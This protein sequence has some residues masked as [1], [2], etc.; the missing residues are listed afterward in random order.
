MSG[1]ALDIA[2]DRLDG[3]LVIE[4]SAGTGKTYSVAAIV[5]RE[6]ALSEDLRIGQILIT[7]FTRN[8][9]AELRDRVRRRLASTI[10]MLRGELAAGDDPVVARIVA[11]GETAAA[12]GRLARALVEFDSA[13]I[14][15]IHGVCVRVLRAAG[16]EISLVVDADVTDR[17]VA[18]VVNDA[19]VGLAE[20]GPLWEEARLAVLVRA[21]LADP[22]LELWYDPADF[23][24]A[25][26]AR[27]ESLRELL[28]ACVARVHASMPA[29]DANAL[30]RRAR[31][32]VCDKGRPELLSALRRRFRMAIV[33][34]AQDTDTQQWRLFLRLFPGDDGR[35]LVSVG[36]PKQAIYGF[37]GAD[38]QA[39]VAYAAAADEH[40]T[41]TINRRSD[42]PL[43]AGLN[44][45][46]D[47]RGF[48][49]GIDYLPVT[50][51]PG[52]DASRII[53]MPAAVEL[54]AVGESNSQQALVEPA[55]SKVLELLESAR[56]ADECDDETGRRVGPEEIC[57]LVRT[58]SV[59]RQIER[60]LIARG[61]PA[62]SGG[63]SSVMAS[64]MAD[65]IRSLLEAMERPSSV[66]RVR[67]AAAT[68]FFG[69]PLAS[70]GRLSEEELEEVQE[71]LMAFAEIL[72]SRGIASL[73]AA[74]EG[75]EPIMRRIASGRH[76]ERNLTDFLHV[77]EVMQLLQTAS[78]RARNGCTPSA[79][80]AI[81]LDLA[82]KDAMHELVSRR[83]ESDADAVRILTIH[84]AK[85]LQFPCVV[86]ADLWKDA[87]AVGRDRG[88]PHV[89]YLD[90]RRRLD[91][92]YALNRRSN[93]AR[94]LCRQA[95]DEESRRLLYVAA[96]R[97]EH[98]L[99]I[100]VAD[101][102]QGGILPQAMNLP[103]RLTPAGPPR[104]LTRDL[105]GRG[106]SG[107]RDLRG[108][109]NGD[110]DP[111]GRG[112]APLPVVERARR[113]ISFTGIVAEGERR[114]HDPLAP[115]APSGGGYDEATVTTAGPAEP[116]PVPLESSLIDLPAGV[117]V[118]RV[119]HEVFEHVDTSAV[120]LEA[121][122]RRV[123]EERA[124]SG[125]LRYHRESLV[126]I[127]TAALETPLGGPFEELTLASIPP[128]DR[129]A[130]MDFE[131]GLAEMAADVTAREIGIVL[132]ESLGES[133]PLFDY[134]AT[135]AGPA[136][137]I[138]L[139]G[140]LVGSIDAV[141]RLPG[142]TAAAPRLLLCDYKSNK[143]HRAGMAEPIGS[144]APQR[145][146]AAM[147]QHHYPLQA[148]L[149]GTAAYRLLRW[150]LPE[151]DPDECIAGVVYAFI[152]GMQGPATPVDEHGRRYGVFTW[153]AP[154]GLWARLSDLLAGSGA[155]SETGE[156]A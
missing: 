123:V 120:P 16:E 49:P 111:G 6:L 65:D 121:E 9:A 13:T 32:L 151:A 24:E 61:V 124:A 12:V 58:S 85:G 106:E 143:L 17:V 136:F 78:F 113:R 28:V 72:G 150:R 142:S 22:F 102:E 92:G 44:E 83:V 1:R 140:L 68:A 139:G 59:G 50:A 69:R 109:D 73:T 122:V 63:T 52:R 62:V 149:Y 64:S 152:R 115:F 100:L 108:G 25:E 153:Q 107:G 82:G 66:G 48:G 145:L 88:E 33:D 105:R 94:D 76:G 51:A 34:E 74:I 46:F 27:L 18:E 98:Y 104:R 131:M 117:A 141:L 130:E 14:S 118:G 43:L 41:L 7:T 114:A 97:A 80:L 147:G 138:G 60:D 11:D 119:V 35:P 47:G 5:T 56:L 134:A 132:R 156:L 112:L 67:R 2:R 129:L 20:D 91:I 55:V 19:V 137:E 101:P 15:T 57:V 4:A 135:L 21:M 103:A 93:R 53:G 77:M 95:Q 125:R 89:F 133:D 90:D 29:A 96:T 10:R 116:L 30:L 81:F 38:V 127:L 154:R 42:G 40:R 86:V 54:V 126:Q 144:Y 23:D 128:A 31:E 26:T 79:A 3:G 37:R 110:R 99:A 87:A 39:Y 84:A 146:A 75:D 155:D 148:L 71:R 36:D 45:G 70:A 8:A